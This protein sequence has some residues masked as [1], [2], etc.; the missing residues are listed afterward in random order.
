MSDLFLSSVR[1][2]RVIPVLRA[3]HADDALGRVQ[4][5]VRAGCRVVELTT[6]TPRWEQA[7]AQAL[8]RHAGEGV[9]VGVGT[10]TTAEQASAAVGLGV[11]FLVSPYAAPGVREVA[12]AAGVPFV[13]GAFTPSELAQAAAAGPVKL[14]P[15]HVGGPAYLT[16]VRTVLP[17]AAIIPTGGIRLDEVSVYLAAGAVAVGVGSGVPDDPAALAELFASPAHDGWGR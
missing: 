4:R 9:L 17:T 8:D 11:A 2:Q 14:F 6:T 7:A 3:D 16:S 5:L 1:A 13:E 10:V 15:A 12:E